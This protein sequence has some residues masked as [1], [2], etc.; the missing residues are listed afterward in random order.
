MKLN[1]DC[2]RDILLTIEQ[3]PDLHHH[4]DFNSETISE[5]F[6]MYSFDEVMYHLHQC[7]LN[8]FFVNPSHNASYSCYT[9]Y[10]LAPSG[11][12]FLANIRNDTF[13]NNVKEICKKLGIISLEGLTTV[14]S[15]CTMML[16]KS[17]FNLP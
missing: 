7:E 9:V 11:H 8:G 6:P 12:T 1:P 2:I 13:F 5:L 15:N 14:A 4:L 16:I 10:D 3:I 17:Y